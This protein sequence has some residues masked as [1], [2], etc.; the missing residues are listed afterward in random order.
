ML[1]SINARSDYYSALVLSIED[2]M[3]KANQLLKDYQSEKSDWFKANEDY[4]ISRGCGVKMKTHPIKEL[5]ERGVA[6]NDYLATNRPYRC[7]LM[8]NGGEA[9]SV[10]QYYDDEWMGTFKITT[11]DNKLNLGT[12]TKEKPYYRLQFGD[13]RNWKWS[14]G[15]EVTLS[16]LECVNRGLNAFYD[17]VLGGDRDFKNKKKKIDKDREHALRL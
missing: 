15:E 3:S 5:F 16:D 10:C 12:L 8:W 7:D 17:F 14:D 11:D 2:R 1:G 13:S 6:P 4:R 9:M